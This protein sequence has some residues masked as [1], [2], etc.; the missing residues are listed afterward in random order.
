MIKSILSKLRNKHF[1]ALAGNGLLSVFG[2]VTIKIICASLSLP[3]LGIWF[4]FFMIQ[5]LCDAVRNGFLGT[6]TVKFYAGTEGHRSEE[7]LGSVWF[8]ASC[9]TGILLLLNVAALFYLPYS[10]IVELT[11]TIKWL[12]LTYLSSL[13]FSVIF[14][15]LQADED[16]TKIL[17]LRM[18]NS[19]SMI[20]I[21]LTMIFLKKMTLE[22]A[23]FYNFLTNAIT[24]IVGLIWG[25]GRLQ[26]IRKLSATTVMELFHFGKFSLATSLSANLLR[27]ADGFIIIGMI[28]P[29]ANAIYQIPVKLME[30][31]EIPLRSF[32]STGMSSMAIANNNGDKGEV[33]HIFKKYSGMLT[34]AFIPL[35]VG[36]ILFADLAI[37][38]LGGHKFDGTQAANLFRCFM[39]ISL[40]YPI[41]RFNGV[42][43]DI[44]HKP[45]I[46]FYKVLIMLA[47]NVAADLVFIHIFG[48]YG[49]ALGILS[50]TL[51]GIFFGHYHLSKYLNYTIPAI[52]RTGYTEIRLLL[53]RNR[54]QD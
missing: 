31:V 26:T 16:Y 44:I 19:G 48:I 1:L 39:L 5:G 2:L 23:L 18:I 30:L 14:W 9:I 52:L 21:F 49:I 47:V 11:I 36:G 33:V 25:I 32:V 17:W 27:A 40:M 50:I 45:K 13:P 4:Y 10:H 12:G 51:S 7:V 37:L 35:A 15:I 28:G 46:N 29:I 20:L 42:T 38:L 8:L 24:S 41:D 22:N 6:A 53:S 3:D 34:I 54:K 43:L